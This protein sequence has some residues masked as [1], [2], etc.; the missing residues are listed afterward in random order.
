MNAVISILSRVL[1]G[2][3]GLGGTGL[4][5]SPAIWVIRR[6][7]IRRAARRAQIASQPAP[8]VPEQAGNAPEQLTMPFPGQAVPSAPRPDLLD[9]VMAYPMPVAPLRRLISTALMGQP[10]LRRRRHSRRYFR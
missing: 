8:L 7:R 3:V 6:R 1:F 5:I 4:G 9:P 2:A 10:M